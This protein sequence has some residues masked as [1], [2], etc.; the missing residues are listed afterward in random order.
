MES[1][2]SG[3]I[4][5]APARL[6]IRPFDVLRAGSKLVLPDH[7]ATGRNTTGIVV[8][9]HRG[10][11]S[12]MTDDEYFLNVGDQVVFSAMSGTEIQMPAP[13]VTNTRNMQTYIVIREADVIAKIESAEPVPSLS[14]EPRSYS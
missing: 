14:V 1:P 9:I 11:Q 4:T 12:V 8:A 13:T 6:V 2:S 10:S 7:V 3:L 5:P